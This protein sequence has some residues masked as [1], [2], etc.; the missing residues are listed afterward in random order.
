MKALKF[1]LPALALMAGLLM[2]STTSF[3]KPEFAKKE[4]KSCTFCHVK[5]GSKDLNEAGTYYKA[6]DHSL[7]GYKAK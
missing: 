2:N 4:A 7:E 6:H 3:G 5:M 1:T